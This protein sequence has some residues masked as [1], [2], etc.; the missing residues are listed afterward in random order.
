MLLSEI[1][2]EDISYAEAVTRLTFTDQERREILKR[3][4]SV[5]VWACPGSGKTSLLVGKLAILSR[6]W[7]DRHRGMCVLSHT[8]VARAEIQ[9]KL[10][11]TES[12]SLLSRPHFI[13]TIQSFVDQFLGIPAAFERFGVRPSVIDTDRFQVAVERALSHPIYAKARNFL[14]NR[15]NREELVRG[16]RFQGADLEIHPK[17]TNELGAGSDS[18]TYLQLVR[19]KEALAADGIFSYADLYALAEW[20]LRE[21]PT[22][23]EA[24]AY[25][26]PLVFID[27]MQDTDVDQWRLLEQIFHP[28]CVIQRFGDNH[29]AIFRS[30]A[31]KEAANFPGP[32]NV[33]IR[34]SYR[35]SPS[36]ASLVGTLTPGEPNSLVGNAERDD[37]RHGVIVFNRETV[38]QVLGFFAQQVVEQVLPLEQDPVVKAVGA[39]GKR[40]DDRHFPHSIGCYWPEYQTAHRRELPVA[41]CMAEHV[42][43]ALAVVRE[44]GRL[45]DLVHGVATGLVDILRLEG[46]TQPNGRGYTARSLLR[47]LRADYPAQYERLAEGVSRLCTKALMDDS[48]PIER[49]GPEYERALAPLVGALS[50]SGR[51]MLNAQAREGRAAV[52]RS[53]RRDANIYRH[54][55]SGKAVDV[56]LSTIHGVKGETHDATLVLE[57]YYRSHD[58]SRALQLALESD[59]KKPTGHLLNHAKRLYVGASRPRYLLF[60]AVCQ[61]RVKASTL[62]RLAEHG[63]ELHCLTEGAYAA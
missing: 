32:K 8:N 49:M 14:A 26:F 36:L 53:A 2:E 42:Q 37:L 55:G 15:P 51:K 61:E 18:P 27:E 56:H 25:R 63:W 43:D 30:I 50:Y 54:E 6:S 28:R 23:G 7:S 3:L 60:V 34:D 29:Q 47:V 33:T 20:H 44:T 21:H 5:D 9:K 12:R 52:V 45:G 62:E 35:L 46:I 19:L 17:G 58:L 57:T 38:G 24:L 39:I 59:P 41:E 22:L 4:D 11:T 1:T 48:C 16:L 31:V 10:A 13:G 40:G